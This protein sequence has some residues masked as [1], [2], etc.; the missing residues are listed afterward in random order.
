MSRNFNRF[1]ETQ[2]EDLLTL[3]AELVEVLMDYS[4]KLYDIIYDCAEYVQQQML[5]EGKI[6][7][8]KVLVDED[9]LDN[10]DLER[11]YA[12]A[13]PLI[14]ELIEELQD[15]II[16]KFV[17]YDDKGE[18]RIERL[19]NVFASI[20]EMPFEKEE[21]WEIIDDFFFQYSIPISEAVFYG[22]EFI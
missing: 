10:L 4:D 6:T 8:Q 22:F 5:E 7:E 13:T 17:I 1:N 19:K 20:D 21:H 15:I 12:T 3:Q 9:Y 11:I 16:D 2:A 14:V 18:E